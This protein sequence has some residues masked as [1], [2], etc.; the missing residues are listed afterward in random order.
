MVTAGVCLISLRHGSYQITVLAAANSAE[1]LHGLRLQFTRPVSRHPARP[2]GAS[3]PRCS[4]LCG[5]GG[6]AAASRPP[7]VPV[8]RLPSI[9]K[10]PGPLRSAAPLLSSADTRQG[11]RVMT[12]LPAGDFTIKVTGFL[13]RTSSVGK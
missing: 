12:G 6:P 5:P 8:S 2:A 3:S 7:A 4:P 1:V 13:S 10:R 9:G 11:N